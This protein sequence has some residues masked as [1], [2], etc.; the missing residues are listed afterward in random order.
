MDWNSEQELCKRRSFQW[1]RLYA[2]RAWTMK[3]KIHKIVTAL[4]AGTFL[5]SSFMTVR[6]LAG[7]K[8]IAADA[9]E[10][11][12]IAM[13]EQPAM[14]P[15]PTI[16]SVPTAEPEPMPTAEPEPDPLPEEMSYLDD[17][18]LATLQTEN[19]DIFGWIEIPDTAISYPLLHGEDNDFYLR[20]NWKK[21]DSIGG[22]IF[23]EATNSPDMDDFHSIIYGHRMRDGSMF[24]E[25]KHY[26]E[27]EFANAHPSIWLVLEDEI[28]RYDVFSVR[29]TPTD[30]LTYRLDLEEKSIQDIFLEDCLD[31]STIDTDIE[32]R[33]DGHVLTLSTCTGNGH[34][35]RL[36]IH[37]ILASSYVRSPK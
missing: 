33:P 25:I 23:L 2:E 11:I 22:S 24:G 15:S 14:S 13:P 9:T 35:K 12:E 30:G 32:P 34:E 7:Y 6:Q 27:Q 21:E 37:S 29:E 26:T 1:L 18:D 4:L 10:A 16:E 8:Q 31:C 20:R 3:N 17:I 19:G 28:C 5:F 36:V